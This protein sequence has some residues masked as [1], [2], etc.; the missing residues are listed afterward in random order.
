MTLAL[1]TVIVTLNTADLE[2]LTDCY[3]LAEPTHALSA[4]GHILIPDEPVRIDVDQ[5]TG[6]GSRPLLPTDTAGVTP[7]G[8]KWRFTVVVDERRGSF[9]SLLPTTPNPAQLTDLMPAGFAI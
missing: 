7:A 1:T 5:L 8:W 4:P 2:P 6:M 9:T 3:V